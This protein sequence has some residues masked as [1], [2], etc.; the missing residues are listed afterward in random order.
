MTEPKPMRLPKSGYKPHYKNPTEH[1]T[2]TL[3]G[4]DH[5]RQL[6]SQMETTFPDTFILHDGPPYANGHLHMG[7]ALN[8]VLKDIVSRSW[9]QRGRASLVR[10]GWD[11]HGLP[12]E[13]NVMRELG[14]EKLAETTPLEFRRLCKEYAMGWQ[15]IQSQEMQGLGVV[16]EW[17]NP[18]MTMTKES[19]GGCLFSFHELVSR[20]LVY[21]AGRP[22]YWSVAEQT[23]IADSDVEYKDSRYLSTFVKFSVPGTYLNLLCW[24]T[25]PWTLPFNQAVAYHP[26]MEYTIFSVAATCEVPSIVQG[27]GHISRLVDTER[28]I[29]QSKCL[30][31]IQKMV[32]ETEL[33][34]LSV[35]PGAVVAD[36]ANNSV[37]DPLYGEERPLWPATFITDDKG[38]GFVHIAPGLGPDDFELAGEQGVQP[39]WTL[40]NDGS[41]PA[42]IPEFGGLSVLGS[43]G[44]WGD[45]QGH[46]M[47]ALMKRG[48][49]FYAQNDKHQAAYSS[50]SDT[51]LLFK[52]QPQVFVDVKGL[53]AQSLDAANT[54]DFHPKVSKNRF[55]SMLENRRDTDWCVSRQRTWGVPLALFIDKQTGAI[56]TDNE[57]LRHTRQLLSEFGEDAWFSLSTEEFLKGTEYSP[58]DYDKLMDVLDVWFESGSTFS[59]VLTD[60]EVRRFQ[61]RQKLG[62][63]PTL[64][65]AD[66]ADLYLEGSD[67]HRGWF[68]SSM[69]ESVALNNGASPFKAVFTHGFVLAG[70]KN[71]KMSKSRGNGVSPADITQK[72]GVDVLRWWVASSDVAN[73]V[74][75]SHETLEAAGNDV[76][77]IRNTLSWLLG[78]A[79]SEPV[80]YQDMETL[81]RL[82]ITKF[83]DLAQTVRGHLA[84]LRFNDAA[85]ALR[86]FCAH[87]LSMNWM[88]WQKD[89]LYCDG[90]TSR[91]KSAAYTASLLFEGLAALLSPF[92]PLLAE[93]AWLHYEDKPTEYAALRLWTFGKDWFKGS[94]TPEKKGTWED[95]L[96]LK[97]DVNAVLE[98]KISSKEM[99]PMEASVTWSL[100]PTLSALDITDDV[101]ANILGVSHF[102]ARQGVREI[103]KASGHKCV[104]CWK[105]L[106]EVQE[107]GMCHRCESVEG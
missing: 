8:K 23:V 6:R 21:R 62:L 107:G 83:M 37:L 74:I 24:T 2:R 40:E 86:Y 33:V 78:V 96:S 60:M 39:R 65:G 87:T 69:L 63:K 4:M 91:R 18:Y 57:V 20:G 26:D 71:V 89:V 34:V 5:Y 84:A 58:D 61:A 80:S 53:V 30:P 75:C 14:P 72:Y 99:T 55:V 25:T 43:N 22:M 88:S 46:V 1:D 67:Q 73:D 106:D 35:I 19:S 31:A 32:G 59:Y 92:T 38:T 103:K 64:P 52:V 79:S 49:L 28:Y 54:V 95:I 3:A 101:F 100:G 41:I 66:V 97:D 56:L 81:D 42:G 13:W 85:H 104:R 105:H 16:M 10:P 17:D 50:R 12:I 11:C 27:V 7:H 102:V 68:Q 90:N 15:K 36:M 47:A 9:F 51:P 77:K 94:F 45:A 48:T 44:R 70:K 76:R 93:Q 82:V 98:P 29:V